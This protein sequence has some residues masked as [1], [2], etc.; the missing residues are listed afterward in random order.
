MKK[1]TVIMGAYNAAS[2]AGR[3]IDSI[4]RQ[5]Y[6]DWLLFICDDGSS[7]H[8]Q[9][10]LKEYEKK[11]PEQIVV[12]QNKEN[13]GLT[14]T[15]NQ[16]IAQVETEYTARMDAD[17]FCEAKRLI[18]QVE[19]LDS[20][21]EY[22]FVGSSI[23]KFDEDGVY[24]IKYYKEQPEKK[25]FLWNNPF[26]HPTIMIRTEVL[27]ELGGYRDI[28]KTIRC[29]D[30][31]LWF[32]LYERGC[33]GFNLQEPLLNYY[34]GKE[35]FPKRRYRYRINEAKVRLEGYWRLNL[36][37]AGWIYVLKPLFIGL[38]PVKVWKLLKKIKP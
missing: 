26:V 7:D 19:F 24:E 5:T 29:E 23:N 8:T 9:Q 31:D 15:L 21:K 14:Y 28:K 1:V 38:I 16:L 2:T 20:H 17:D 36:L 30:Y 25:D 32:R 37:P 4:V 6:Q 3:A 13:R 33:A 22:A 18:K 34:E 11:Y 10:V 35:S 12:Y 27:K